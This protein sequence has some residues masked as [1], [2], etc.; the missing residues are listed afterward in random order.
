MTFP[1]ELTAF[2]TY[3]EVFGDTVLLI[4]TYDTEQAARRIVASGLKPR[5]VRLDSG[6]LIAVSRPVP[7]ILDAGGLRDTAIFVSSDLHEER[8]AEMVAAGA[9]IDGFGVGGA[10]STG[11]EAPALGAVQVGR[12]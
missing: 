3:V 8:I 4:D 11:R 5:A 2:R 7:A 1:D 9:P 6:D 12:G 10:L